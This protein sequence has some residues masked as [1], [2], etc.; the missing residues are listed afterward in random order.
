M[1][2][3]QKLAFGGNTVTLSPRYGYEEPKFGKVTHRDTLAG[4]TYSYKWYNKYAY[5]LVVNNISAADKAL[6]E[7]WWNDMSDV[8]FTPDFDA[9]PGTTRT[10]RIVNRNHPLKMMNV[11]GFNTT[12]KYE[13]VL[14]LRETTA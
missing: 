7:T 9:A 3:T 2:G 14:N 13:G 5:D 12:A 1:A 6:I 8:V 11:P 4:T 10:V